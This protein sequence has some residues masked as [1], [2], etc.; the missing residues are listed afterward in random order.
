[1]KINRILLSPDDLGGAAPAAPVPAAAS[2]PAAAPAPASAGVPPPVTPFGAPK[3]GSAKAKMFDKLAAVADKKPATPKPEEP[4]KPAEPADPKAAKAPDSPDAKTTPDDKKEK[5]N[6]WKLYEESKK[7]ISDYE[8]RVAELEKLKITPERQ[9]E[10]EALNARADELEK[11][12]RYVNYTKSKEFQEQ[13]QK[14][15]DEAWKRA[16]TDLNELTI[17]DSNG[18]ERPLQAT[19][20]LDLVNMPLQQARA[21]AVERFGDFADDVM[22]HRKEIRQLFDKQSSRLDEVKKEGIERDKQRQAQWEQERSVVTKEIQETWNAANE[23]AKNHEKYGTYFK[24]TEGDQ[25]G[26]QRLAKGFELAD[27]AFSENPIQAKN[28]E[29]RKAIIQRHA[30]VRNRCAAFG[31]LVY[32]NQKSSERIA[33]LQKELEGYKGADPQRAGSQPKAVPAKAKGG[34]GGLF[35]EMEKLA[36]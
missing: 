31:R 22:A 1:M 20:I 2:A 11:E 28:A 33:E 24:P 3:P 32:Q 7:K 14:P 13:Y 27:R 8:S 23:E 16:M 5:P 4:A 18:D 12:I 30:A 17:S 6:P 34:L 35:A 25:E 21:A 26:N 36:K 29:E 15:Y 9:K 10:I 19:D